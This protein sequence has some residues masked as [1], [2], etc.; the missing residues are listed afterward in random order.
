MAKQVI[1]NGETGLVTRN[2][3]N[4][5]F[6][7]LYGALETH[8]LRT[9][10]SSGSHPIT[11]GPSALDVR[12]VVLFG[13][14]LSGG[15][16]NIFNITG[17][18]TIATDGSI[19]CNE[20]GSYQFL[21]TLNY[22]RSTASGVAKVNVRIT[23][24]NVQ[25]GGSGDNWQSSKDDRLAKSTAFNLNLTAGQVLRAEIVR[26]STGANDGSLFATTPTTSGWN[27]IPSSIMACYKI[28]SNL[29]T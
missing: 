25:L 5:N 15:G 14:T 24:D 16:Q 18:L 11:Q 6:D 10:I 21:M 2:K 7:E 23:I 27:D 3:L 22:G 19:T 26:D 20:T 12:H 1:I 13:D 4:G 17:E 28:H 9:T 8:F 29:E